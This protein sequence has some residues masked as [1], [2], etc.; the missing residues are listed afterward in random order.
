M[1]WCLDVIF[2]ED[3]RVIW[4]R[5]FAQNESIIRQL[6]LNFLKKFQEICHYR[7][8]NTKIA[9]KTLRKILI[10]SDSDMEKLIMVR[11]VLVYWRH[12]SL[13]RLLKSLRL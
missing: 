7:I 11:Q 3:D 6:A 12:L 5:N 13:S 2:R 10:G 4:N 9:L 1:H 8:G